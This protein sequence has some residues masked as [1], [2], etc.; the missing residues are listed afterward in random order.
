[1]NNQE[2]LALE[3]QFNLD[4][5]EL[6]TKFLSGEIYTAEEYLRNKSVLESSFKYHSQ[7]LKVKFSGH[8]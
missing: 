1:M 8:I 4:M 5:S 3:S 2:I 6:K 7:L